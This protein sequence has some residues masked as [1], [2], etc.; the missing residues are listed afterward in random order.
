MH[1]EPPLAFASRT[2]ADGLEIRVNFGMFAGR[3]ATPAE[4]DDLAR[5]LLPELSEVSIVGEHRLE[6]TEDVEATVHQVRIDVPRRLLPAD[7]AEA[8]EMGARIADAAERWARACIADRHAA[9]V[10]EV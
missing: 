1:V 7:A 8:D 6:V 5:D 10:D 3:E 9:A 2:D 4:L